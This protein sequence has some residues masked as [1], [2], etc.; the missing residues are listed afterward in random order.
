MKLTRYKLVDLVE[1]YSK[2]CDIDNL[3]IDDVSGVNKDKEF[4]EPS[5]QVGSNTSKYRIVPNGYFACNLMHVGRDRLLPIAFNHSG[6]EKI[7]S[8]AYTVFKLKEDNEILSE[9]F[10]MMLKSGESD[11]YFWF[12]TDSSVRDGMSWSDMCDIDIELPSIDIQQKYVD[13]YNG[14]NENI[15][16]YESGLEDL[17]LVCD[18]YVEKL[19]HKSK[20]H[21]LEKYISKK[22]ERNLHNEYNNVKGV[23]V[24]KVFREPTS[25]VNKSKLTNYKIV[26]PGE[27][28]FVQTTNNE[29]VFSNALNKT[30]EVILVTS[31]NE[32]FSVDEAEI[33]PEYLKIIFD[34]TEFDRYARFHS[35]GSAR[36]TFTW[37]DLCNVMIP[38]P[39]IEI[40]QNI[41]DIYNVYNERKKIAEELKEL[42]S[43][44]CPILIK[45]AI[46][47]AT[48]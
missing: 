14:M 42:Q 21:R 15:K 26:K 33:V 4:F 18:A 34:R 37:D 28:S 25:K 43:N 40:Q 44:M 31:V 39:P 2:Q 9:Y 6:L 27:F 29:K 3:T 30:D 5:K 45:G 19:I 7:V 17:K 36:E 35:W 8:P 1:L 24:Y 32:V 16:A 46:E 23:S 48:R 13:I 20:L 38:I 22:N 47:E 41:A 12:F 11:R 10:F